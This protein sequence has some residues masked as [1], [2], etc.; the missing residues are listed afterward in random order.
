MSTTRKLMQ[1]GFVLGLVIV[2]A[3]GCKNEDKQTEPKDQFFPAI[4][5]IKSQIAKVDTSLY[6]IMRIVPVDSAHNDTTYLR[7]EQ[8]KDAASEFLALPDL[9]QPEYNGRFTEQNTFDESLGRVVMIYSPKDAKKEEVQRQEVL[10]KPQPGTSEDQVT[11]IFININQSNKDSSIEKKMLWQVDESF[12][13]TTIKQYPG[14]PEVTST[15]KV[16][17]NESEL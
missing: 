14:K 6:S 3:W 8:F 9:T 1:A 4:P 16:S 17:W 13:V 15:Y 10:I 5:Y 2:F 11:S 12:Q 7:R